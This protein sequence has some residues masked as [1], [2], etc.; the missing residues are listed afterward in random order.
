MDPTP[1]KDYE[2]TLNL[3]SANSFSADFL[4]LNDAKTMDVNSVQNYALLN[5]LV[6]HLELDF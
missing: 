3:K 2:Y 4:L 5:P 1:H 6:F